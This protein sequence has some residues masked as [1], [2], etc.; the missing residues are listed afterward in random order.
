MLRRPTAVK[1]LQ[2]DRSREV[3]LARFERE[4]QLTAQLTHPNTV[5]VFD[6]GRTPDGLFYYAME[7]LTGATL[8]E[9]LAADGPQPVGR[10]VHIMSQVAGALAEAHGVGLIHRD[11]KPA[12]II[13]AEQGGVVDVAKVVDFGLVKE[14]RAPQDSALTAHETIL[15]TPLYMAPEAIRDPDAVDA[16]GDVYAL[17]AVGYVLLTGTLLFDAESVIELCSHHLHTAPEPPSQRLG[18]QVPEAFE[19]LLLQCLAKDPD[20]RPAS[21]L[22]LQRALEPIGREHGWNAEQARKWWQEHQPA[23]DRQRS[24]Q[25]ADT[26]VEQKRRLTRVLSPPGA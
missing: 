11:I 14:I 21:A 5:T 23:I 22:E 16:R 2:P 7:L 3:D 24:S 20:E 15:G 9:V 13:L 4:V 18:R 6:F 25:L 17:G 26:A 19:E 8:A 1:V 12:N 10:I